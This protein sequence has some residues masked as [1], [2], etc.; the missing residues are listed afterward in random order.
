MFFSDICEIKNIASKT[1]CAVFVVPDSAKVEIKN[2]IIVEP[3]DKSIISMDDIRD[4]LARLGK[5]QKNDLFIIIRPAD[6]LGLDSAN[7]MLKNLEEPQDNVHFVLITSKASK[8]IPTI[9]SRSA[10]YILREDKPVDG[11]I[12]ADQKIMDL[13]KRLVVAKPADLPAI[14]EEVAK[15]KDGVRNH[16]M[17][18]LGTAIEILYKSYF[19]TGKDVF[20]KKLPKFITAYENIEKNGHVKLHLVADLC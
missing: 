17:D 20:V 2:A 9:L 5:K 7:A 12:D 16:A 8:I 4:L 10:V 1:G 15:V 18:V 11:A 13:A 14:A 6:L 3:T 19:K